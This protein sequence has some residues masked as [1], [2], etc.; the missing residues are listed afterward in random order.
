MAR[1]A[2]LMLCHQNPG[3]IIRQAKLLTSQGDA[4]AIHVDAGA[5]P[6]VFEAVR[7]ELD[8]KPNIVLARR[9]RCGWGEWSLV[10]A[11]LNVVDAA[12]SAF[13]FTTHFFLVSGDCMP[14]KS[15]AQIHRVLDANDYDYIENEDFYESSWIKTGLRGE[16]LEY[17]H[18][19]NERNSKWLFYASLKAQQKLG[20]R[21]RTP[22]GLHMRVGSQWWC[23]RRG[24]VEKLLAFITRN[25]RVVR[26]FRTT[27]IADETFFQTLVGHLVPQAEILSRPMTFLLF[28]DYGMPVTFHADHFDFLKGQDFL[29]ARKISPHAE[30]LFD[31]LA[32]LFAE[33]DNNSVSSNTGAEVYKFLTR[34]GRNGKRFGPRF[35]ETGQTLGD[36]RLLT[37]I[38]CK[39]WHVAL[40]LAEHVHKAGGARGFGFVFDSEQPDLPP[41]GNYENARA[42]R[43]QHRRA[44]LNIL[45]NQ[46][47]TDAVSIC[48]D[49]SN[50]ESLLDLAKDGCTMHVLEIG[51]RFDDSYL[52]GHAD[53]IGLGGPTLDR[54]A[55]TELAANLR[56][57]FAEEIKALRKLGLPAMFRMK[58]GDSPEEIADILA[59]F[60]GIHPKRALPIAQD[61]ALFD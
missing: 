11:T 26:F 6:G 47:R 57:T 30:K 31:R 46:Q 14:I 10:Q 60:A 20:L 39:K 32:V 45:A 56:R 25:R 28:S 1:L 18:W 35:W 34:Q 27:W 9:V 22:A 4:L 3:A 37:V 23:L 41:L 52:I 49:P 59:G 53:R 48:I 7:K 29:L 21:R 17:R 50:L 36:G 38:V 12:V 42:K 16:R 15:A 33:P 13:P 2:Y 24:T 5:R 19:F 58:A 8:G 40:R 51:C 44:F 61:P 55:Q 54:A 43:L